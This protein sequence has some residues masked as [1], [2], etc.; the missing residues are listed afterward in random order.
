MMGLG[1]GIKEV[2]RMY[3]L[4]DE[5]STVWY[6][7]SGISFKVHMNIHYLGFDYPS[8]FE[9]IWMISA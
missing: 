5:E 2:T 7:A 3:I 9:I 6:F 8:A 4:H 1:L